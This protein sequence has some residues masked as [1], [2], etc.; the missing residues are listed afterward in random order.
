MRDNK[1]FGF[2]VQDVRFG[3]LI[4]RIKSCE[5]RL[6]KYLA[7]ETESIPELEEKIL[8]AKHGECVYWSKSYTVNSVW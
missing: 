3:G 7:G 2:D 5:A 6:D 8:E 1:P 4:Q